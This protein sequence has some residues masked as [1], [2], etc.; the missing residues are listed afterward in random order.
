MSHAKDINCSYHHDVSKRNQFYI[1]DVKG[2]ELH[3]SFPRV[4]VVIKKSADEG[5]FVIRQKKS[6]GHSSETRPFSCPPFFMILYYL[7]FFKIDLLR[8]SW[9]EH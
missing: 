7:H 2:F 9:R 3:L 8:F 4:N 5:V 6:Y 1:L